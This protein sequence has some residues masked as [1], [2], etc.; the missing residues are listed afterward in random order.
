M[1]RRPLFWQIYPSYILVILL[2]MIAAYWFFSRELRL[3]Y[4]NEVKSDLE[5]RAVLFEERI[6]PLL[7][8]KDEVALD[9]LCKELGTRAG[10]RF[11]AIAFSGEVVGDS[12][13]DPGRMENHAGRPEVS[14]A[15]RGQRADMVHFSRTLQQNMMY[16]AVPIRSGDRIVGAVRAARAVEDIH[17]NLEKVMREIVFSGLLVAFAAAVVGWFL[18]RR[19]S[20]PLEMMKRG[21]EEFAQGRFCNRLPATGSREICALAGAMNLMAAQLDDRIRTISRQRNEQQAVL[22]S[23]A[24]G[25]LALDND[26]RIIHLNRAAAELFQVSP[27]AVQGRR[28]QEV[29]RKADLQRFV[30]RVL[31][32]RV[33]VEGDIL[34][35]AATGDRHLQAHG[36]LLQDG[37]GKRLGVVVVLN[38]VTRLHRLENLR[39]DFVA[40][41]SHELKTPI[42]CIKGSV[43]TLM[44]GAMDRREDAD[45]FLGIIAKQAERLNA[46]I[47]DLLDLSRIEQ[48]QNEKAIELVPSSLR[49]VLQGAIYAC[50]I[51][52]RDKGIELVLSCAPEITADIN[53]PLLEQAVI[54]LVDN[55]IKYSDAGGTVW[56]E[57]QRDA[58]QVTIRVR[59]QGCGIGQEHLPRLFERF[60][61]V[62]KAR[63]RRVGGTGL[64]LSIVKHIVQAH[65]GR[66][67][68]DS[69]P[70]QGSTFSIVLRAL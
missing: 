10:T 12:L 45:R 31:T 54:N 33:P 27:E 13:E 42:T 29:V 22:T 49:P 40:N 63:S 68:V 67:T 65:H 64:G 18:S 38:D 61:R 50:D 4:L 8:A 36:T 11:T 2:A 35:P 24:E 52:A 41:V 66:V 6:R 28:I 9:R 51:K 14:Q 37:E 62:D 44:G 59:D 19:L 15:L 25:V 70:G 58:D 32:S 43:E 47:D 60:Y 23:M 69:V 1:R 3:F 34:L 16:V 48:N 55:A 56:I 7:L 20:R 53:P 39:R 21:A 17:W 26:E 46:I 57:T 5:I 30:E